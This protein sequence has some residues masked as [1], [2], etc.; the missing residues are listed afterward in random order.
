MHLRIETKDI[1]AKEVLKT[2]LKQLQEVMDH[3]SK[4]F[5][6]TTP[7]EHKIAELR[8]SYIICLLYR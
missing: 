2:G 8:H 4:T 3:V 6:V 5:E 7:Y 1:P